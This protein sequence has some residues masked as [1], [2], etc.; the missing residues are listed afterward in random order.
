VHTGQRRR[1]WL[2]AETLVGL[3]NQSVAIRDGGFMENW[4]AIPTGRKWPLWKAFHNGHYGKMLF[5]ESF[6]L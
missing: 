3:E 5:M 1:L 4:A 6:V 2:P